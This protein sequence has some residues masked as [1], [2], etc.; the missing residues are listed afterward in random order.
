MIWF[1][2]AKLLHKFVVAE[3]FVVK[4]IF[5]ACHPTSWRMR[6][7]QWGWNP[8]TNRRG[9]FAIAMIVWYKFDAIQ[10]TILCWVD[11]AI[12][13]PFLQEKHTSARAAE[14]CSNRNELALLLTSFNT[15]CCIC[16]GMSCQMINTVAQEV[17]GRNLP[18]SVWSGAQF[19]QDLG[20]AEKI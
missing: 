20:V 11:L 10:L 3:V 18:L 5:S 16:M 8:N 7:N 15:W 19:P 9:T 1:V 2:A 13:L 14:N 6:R 12:K 17:L 4:S